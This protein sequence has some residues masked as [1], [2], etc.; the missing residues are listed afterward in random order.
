MIILLDR[1]VCD[2]IIVLWYP[3]HDDDIHTLI[4]V[5]DIKS[6]VLLDNRIAAPYCLSVY[7]FIIN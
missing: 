6:N 2:K 1:I 4:L 7:N 5:N 3:N